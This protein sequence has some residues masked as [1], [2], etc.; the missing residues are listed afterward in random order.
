MLYRDLDTP[1]LLIDKERLEKN[2]A[3]MQAYANKYKVKLRPHTK[4]HKMPE[5]AMLQL[6][7]GA[8]GIAVAKVGE[9][10]CMAQH[11]IK[12]IFIANEMF[13]QRL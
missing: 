12:D 8:C 13:L 9:A 11:G 10:E 2:L 1:A 5:I 7:K 6:E 3:D 4:T